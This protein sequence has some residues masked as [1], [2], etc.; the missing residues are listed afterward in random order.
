MPT[1]A[2]RVLVADDE[3]DIRAR[4]G[5]A[6]RRAGCEPAAVATP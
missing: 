3:D 4:V 2:P 6:V 5:P 1:A